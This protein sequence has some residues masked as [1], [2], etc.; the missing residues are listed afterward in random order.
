MPFLN[1][2]YPVTPTL[3]IEA[4]QERLI[5]DE[6]TA[7]AERAVGTEGEMVSEGGGGGGGDGGA[8]DT[9]GWG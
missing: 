6:E 3:S 8:P 5:W 1:T 4:A 7:V 2:L 9:K